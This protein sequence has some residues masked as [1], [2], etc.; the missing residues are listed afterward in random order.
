M[1]DCEILALVDRLGRCLLSPA[2]FHHRDHLAN[3]DLIYEYYSR[4]RL[5]SPKAKQGWI[6]SDLR[7][8]SS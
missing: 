2:V 1:T 8:F 5:D 7:D 3:K 4:E 6:P